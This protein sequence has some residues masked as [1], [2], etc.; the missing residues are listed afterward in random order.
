MKIVKKRLICG[1]YEN[2]TVMVHSINL[3]HVIPFYNPTNIPFS[4]NHSSRKSFTRGNQK[5]KISI[6]KQQD[7][8]NGNSLTSGKETSSPSSFEM[9]DESI[10]EI[11]LPQSSRSNGYAFEKYAQNRQSYLDSLPSNNFN[12]LNDGPHST[13]ETEEMYLDNYTND[14]D[15]YPMKSSPDLTNVVEPEREDF[16]VNN[17]QPPDYAPKMNFNSN[18]SVSHKSHIK[19]KTISHKPSLTSH[20]VKSLAHSRKLSSVSSISTMD[21]HNIDDSVNT[22]SMSSTKKSVSSSRN[23]SPTRNYTAF[24]HNN[25]INKIK[26]M[27]MTKET[28]HARNN[29]KITVQIMAKPPPQPQAPTRS[30]T[31]FEL[32]AASASASMHSMPSSASSTSVSSGS[33]P[34]SQPRYS[35]YGNGGS[36]SEENSEINVLTAFHEQVY[37]ALSNRFATLQLIRNSMR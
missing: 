30:K 1:S 13:S 35:S 14:L 8:T 4:H 5:L 15:Y 36:A 24:N 28:I 32:R 26:K 23:G 2:Q 9:I 27:D 7:N 6:S 34:M 20:S 22:T 19:S 11:P 37:H 18:S 12:K 31:S 10:D 16:P 25:N 17:A 21:L 33:G 3:D 29:R